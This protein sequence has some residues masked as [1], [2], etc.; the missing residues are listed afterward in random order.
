MGQV[1]SAIQDKL[2]G[3][4][5][6]ERQVRKIT[7][8]VFDRL[9]DDSKD[10]QGLAFDQLYIA[11]L[12]VYN[13]INKHL[14]GPHHD[15]PSKEKL[16]S[17]MK[18]YDINLNGLLEREEFAE[19]IRKLTKDSLAAISLKLMIALVV[20]PAIA[21]M[22]KR[23]TERVPHVGPVVQRLPNSV[24]ASLVTLGVVLLQKDGEDCV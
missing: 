19:F 23:A 4:Q 3:R 18:E 24:Y 12:C 13:D 21:L 2:Q 6:R 14:P 7:D 8:K 10:S 16:N 20:A 15:P 1:L 11:V 22:T 17:M 5:W 9:K